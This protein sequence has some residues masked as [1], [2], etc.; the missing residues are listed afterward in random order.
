MSEPITL[1]RRLF[2]KSSAVAGGGFALAAT[3]PMAARATAVSG[4]AD[5]NAFITVHPDNSITIVG[6]NPEIGQGIKTMLPMLIAEEL[7]ADWDNVTI[8]QADTD[9]AK[10]G[11]QLAGGSFATPMNWIPMRQAG[12]AARAMLIAAAAQRWGVPASSLA[13]EPGRVVEKTGSRSATFGELAADAAMME[14]PEADSLTLKDQ[15]DF[16]IIGRAIGGVDSPRIVRGEPIFG[17]DTQLDGMV[18]AA[19]ERSPVFGAKL[20]SADLD[21]AKAQTGVIDAFTIAGNPEVELVDGI[22]VIADN[23]WLANKARRAL[24]PQW[25]NG[26][27]ASHSTAG[28]AQAAKDAWA[29]GR[30]D[31]VFAAKGD[32]DAAFAEADQVLEAEYSYPFLAHVAMEPM[33]CTALM[34]GDG[35]M[36]MWAPSQTPQGGQQAV[37]SYLGLEPSQVTVHIT[38]M[39]GGFGRRLNNDYMVQVAAIAKEMPGT[40]VQLIWSR[41]DDVRSDFYRP[42]GW[43]KLRAAVN[44]EG[45]LTG[46]ADH[47]V[48]F[49]L[50]DGAYNPAAMPAEE[51]PAKYV[52]NL[53]FEQ[54]KLKSAVP[55][56]ALR[57]P[58]SNALAFVMQSF[59]DEVAHATGKDL[60]TL[61]LEL[62]DGVEAEPM[63]QGFVG[64]Q[65]GF[66]APRLQD[67][68]RKVMEMSNWGQP[69]PEGHAKGFGFYYSH[70]GYFAEV[71]EASLDERNNPVVHNVWAAGDVGSQIINPFGAMNQVEGSIIDG[72]GQAI[73]LAVE[74]EGGAA[75]QSNFHNYPLPR[76][77]MTPQIH[78]EW[79]LSD[80]AP[81]GLGE[82]A[83]PPVIPALTNALFA[84]TGKR[85]RSLP[86]DKAIF[87]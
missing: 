30:S 12:A 33:N 19:F 48:T 78:V 76:M 32:V 5:L 51:F 62:T 15:A 8:E 45:K 39:G 83:L 86:I 37:A 16:R 54:T 14:V 80:N 29:A 36:E 63:T 40:P 6:K 23:W 3:F 10:Y 1:S 31:E 60:P 52:D 67:V 77:P 87:A 44:A 24:S 34:H 46:W 27:W 21:A 70:M 4:P 64:P 73:Q 58:T 59:L 82:P 53:K 57:A 11:P 38:R 26:E 50:G 9:A 55:M 18:Y 69:A 47:F 25:D 61:M 75:K 85:V 65:P 49:D 81:T 84:L 71:V 41:E 28:Y 68:T 17:V 35:T 79:V 72:I 56:G 13:T 2:L 20:V 74:I 22:A 66:S 42:A 43:H 7:D